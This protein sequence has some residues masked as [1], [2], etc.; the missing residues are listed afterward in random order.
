MITGMN[1]NGL[2]GQ[3]R[4]ATVSSLKEGIGEAYELNAGGIAKVSCNRTR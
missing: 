3:K 1:I 4:Q 2:D